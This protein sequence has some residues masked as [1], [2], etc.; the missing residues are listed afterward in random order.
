MPI[1]PIEPAAATSAVRAFLVS[2][3]LLDSPRAVANDILVFLLFLSDSIR[4]KSVFFLPSYE[5][6]SDVISPS[7]KVI[8]RVAYLSANS[9]LWVTITT[10]FLS[11]I[12]FKRSIIW[13][14]V[15]ESRAPVGSSASKISG[16]FTRALAIATRCICPPDS[17][18][19]RLSIWSSRPTSF[20]AFLALRI[21]SRL[22][23]PESVKARRTFCKIVWCGIK[24]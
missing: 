5:S 4:S 10:S 13:R 7:F 2:K 9:G 3:L 22:E 15:S 20:K 17:W 12:C 16:S 6:E 1:I 18:L 8:M 19:G 23:I 21:L 14:L 24:L 11:A